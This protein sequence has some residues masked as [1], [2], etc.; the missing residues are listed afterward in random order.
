MIFARSLDFTL[1]PFNRIPEL[2]E[3]TQAFV[4]SVLIMNQEVNNTGISV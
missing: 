3:N 2:L 1:L 4:S